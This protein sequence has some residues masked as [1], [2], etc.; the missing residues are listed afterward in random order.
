M[1]KI[2]V[3]LSI[4]LTYELNMMLWWFNS[5]TSTVSAIIIGRGWGTQVGLLVRQTPSFIQTGGGGDS[6]LVSNA[7]SITF[8][9]FPFSF[10]GPT[11]C[12]LFL[13]CV[14][15]TFCSA[16]SIIDADLVICLNVRVSSPCVTILPGR[17]VSLSVSS[18]SGNDSA[19]E[20]STHKIRQV[21]DKYKIN[22]ST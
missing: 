9:F 10:L 12:F 14:S 8:A 3:N 5:I 11:F 22:V 7:S 16:Q 15:P 18:S 4:H 19:F 13:M 1:E 17:G 6:S 2:K 21:R 20:R